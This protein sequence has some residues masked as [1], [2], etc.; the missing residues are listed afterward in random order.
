MSRTWPTFPVRKRFD[1]SVSYFR[2][3]SNPM[4]NHSTINNLNKYGTKHTSEIQDMA[5]GTVNLFS[6][7]FAGFV[8]F[9]RIHSVTYQFK[10][11]GE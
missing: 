4:K 7:R 10:G 6:F 2:P 3:V 1:L 8:T 5:L 9:A 11:L